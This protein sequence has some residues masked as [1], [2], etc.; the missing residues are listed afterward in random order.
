[1]VFHTIFRVFKNSVYVHIVVAEENKLTV[2]DYFV[3]FL[4]KFFSL[5]DFLEEEGCWHGFIPTGSHVIKIGSEIG[6]YNSS[7]LSV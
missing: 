6:E 2:V 1:M 4:R 7:I 5:I 3:A